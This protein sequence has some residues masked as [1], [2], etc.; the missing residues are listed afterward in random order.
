VEY[1]SKITDNFFKG[2]QLKIIRKAI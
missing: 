1:Q 2:K